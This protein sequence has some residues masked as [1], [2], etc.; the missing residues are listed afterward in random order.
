MVFFLSFAAFIQACDSIFSCEI[1][2]TLDLSQKAEKRLSC[3]FFFFF[4]GLFVFFRAASVTYR[5]SQARAVASGL[6]QSYSNLGS[7]PC[8]RPI[9]RL[10]AMLDP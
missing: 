9:P 7:E 1:F 5:G 8:L 6:L 10:T 4:F 3:D 2:F